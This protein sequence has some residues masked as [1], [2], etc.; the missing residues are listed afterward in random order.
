MSTL[1]S[2]IKIRRRRMIQ[3]GDEKVSFGFLLYVDGEF[4]ESFSSLQSARSFARFFDKPNGNVEGMNAEF[5]APTEEPFDDYDESYPAFLDEVN[6]EYDAI[7]FF[8]CPNP[9][10]DSFY[11]RNYHDPEAFTLRDDYDKSAL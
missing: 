2:A 8:S 9:D 1:L 7:G 5:D 6:R 10:Y 3:V 4:K 11:D